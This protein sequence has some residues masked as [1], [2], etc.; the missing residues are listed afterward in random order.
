MADNRP[1]AVLIDSTA[2]HRS[3]RQRAI[4]S[5]NARSAG[6]MPNFAGVKSLAFANGSKK[7]RN[8]ASDSGS[9]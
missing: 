6:N 5:V 8:D 4:L 2:T 1:R 3:G 9:I 7:F